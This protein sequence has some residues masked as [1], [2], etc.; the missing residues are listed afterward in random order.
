M[1]KLSLPIS[2]KSLSLPVSVLVLSVLIYLLPDNLSSYLIYD[3][4]LLAQGELWRLLSSHF[5]H[6]NFNH[7]LLNLAG[8][9]MLWALH[10][11]HYDNKNYGLAFIISMIVC[12]AGIYFFDT[13]MQRYV[14]LSGVLHGIF[15][16]GAFLDIRRGWKSGYLLVIGVIAKVAYEQV[17]GASAEVESIINASVA[18]DA[19]LWG[20]VGGLVA[21]IGIIISILKKPTK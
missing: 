19:H 12:S 10:G 7:L 16:W 3:R 8:L 2:R 1:L 11:D 18:I 20:T 9:T 6:T 14:G 13:D 15:I 17:F 5:V 4:D 21:S